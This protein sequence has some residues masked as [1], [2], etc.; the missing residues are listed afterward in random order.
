MIFISHT[1]AD[2]PIVR[3]ISEDIQNHNFPVWLDEWRIKAGECIVSAIEEAL[4]SC[5]FVLVVL[6]PRAVESGWVDRE[7]KAKYWVEV[8]EG[9]VRVIPVL[10]ENCS[11]PTLLKTKRYV[12]LVSDYDSGISLLLSSIN[13]Y[14]AEDSAHDFYAYAPIVSRQLASS[15]L[16]EARNAYWDKFC[17]N[18]LLKNEQDRFEL[19]QVN[20]VHYLQQWGLTVQQLRYELSRFG[21]DTCN[22]QKFSKDLADALEGFQRANCMRHID[23]MFGELTYRELHKM[24]LD[25]MG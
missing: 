23:G 13:G 20:T 2:K 24:H 7:W 25:T 21:F 6:S 15:P 19:Q 3:K 17:E 12:D 1:S 10:I 5:R 9:R 11:V 18:L 4:T 8:K 16:L 22:N 14:I